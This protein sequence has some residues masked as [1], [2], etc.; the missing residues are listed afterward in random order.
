MM[1]PEEFH[2]RRESCTE[3]YHFLG[4][5]IR[6][7]RHKLNWTLANLGEKLGISHQQVQKYEHGVVHIS[8]ARIYKLAH[9]L[10]VSPGYFYEG[11]AEYIGVNND[12]EE[13]DV[14]ISKRSLPLSILIIDSDPLDE[15]YTREALKDCGLDLDFHVLHNGG[16]VLD[17][18]KNKNSTRVF[19]RPDVIFMELDLPQVKGMQI[20]TDIKRDRGLRDIPIIILSNSLSKKNMVESYK[21]YAS[22]YILKSFEFEKFKSQLHATVKYWSCIC[23]PRM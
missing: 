16:Q 21:N 6:E 5:R 10:G 12:A 7:R 1:A 13:S 3:L 15:L 2:R 8:A 9:I 19:P 17:L 4:N 11:F 18:L 23:L 22:G 14:L 20:L